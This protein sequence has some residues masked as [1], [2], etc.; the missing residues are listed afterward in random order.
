[1]SFPLSRPTVDAAAG[2]AVCLGRTPR[3]TA[4]VARRAGIFAAEGG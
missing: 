2:E 1:M 4:N 3:R